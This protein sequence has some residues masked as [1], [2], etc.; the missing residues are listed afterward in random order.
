[1]LDDVVLVGSHVDQFRAGAV[2]LVLDMLRLHFPV[3]H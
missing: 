2:G 3:S 1:L